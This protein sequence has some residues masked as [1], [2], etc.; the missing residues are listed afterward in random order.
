MAPNRQAQIAMFDLKSASIRK[1]LTW[2]SMLA[3]CAA[4]LLAAAAFLAY[5][6]MNFRNSMVRIFSIRANV[7]GHSS[8][9]A[10]LFRDEKNA[11]QTLAALKA[12]VHATSAAIYDK[13]GRLFATYFREEPGRAFQG[14]QLLSTSSDT[15]RF[16]RQHL[17][18]FRRIVFQ[19]EPIGTVYI[20]S[21]LAEMSSR[22][23]QYVTI[24][25]IVLFLS[26]LVALLISSKLQR[27]FTQPVSRLAEAARAVSREKDYSVRVA[28]IGNRD[29]LGLLVETFNEMLSEIQR[30]DVE[31]QQARSEVEQKVRERTAELEAANTELDAANKELEAFTYSV[32]HDLRAPLR[33]IDGFSRILEEECASQL[34]SSATRYLQ[35]IREGTHRMGLLVDDLLNLSRIGRQEVRR[36]VTGLN[37]LVQEVQAELQGE[38]AGRQIEWR[39]GPLP[40]ADCDPILVK[41]VFANLLS[42]AVKYTRPRAEAVIEA[43]TLRQDGETVVFVRVNGV[44]FSMK[45]ADKLF[46]VFQRLHRQ[47]DFE[48]TGVGLATVQR[49]IHKHGGTIWAEAELDRGATFYFTLGAADQE[50]R[51]VSLLAAVA[52]G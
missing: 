12:D 27:T 31:L 11:A 47:E 34:D 35:R 6:L 30:R 41:Q 18:V 7:I 17:I 1:K 39:I 40:F 52:D 28:S 43:G 8:V 21:D 45:Y 38:A 23:K 36:Q 48:G 13:E 32:S 50:A 4:L 2:M 9:S 16:E 20:Q 3:S 37:S 29:E 26:T 14:P 44:G 10:L 24:G 49:I 5:D 25:L 42:N 19:G 22:L 15:S 46:G 51:G 33:H